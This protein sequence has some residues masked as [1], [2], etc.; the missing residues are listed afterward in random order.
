MFLTVLLEKM[1]ESP[2]DC[3]EIKLVNL[4]GNQSWI[5]L[6]RTDAEAEAPILWPPN[7][8]SQFI[9]KDPDSG[10]V[11][12]KG[13]GGRQWIRWL[14]DITDSMDISLRQ[15]QEIVKD[16][17]AWC[18]AVYVVADSQTRLDDWTRA[19]ITHTYIYTHKCVC[20]YIYT[21]TLQYTHTH[22]LE[23][24]SSYEVAT[25]L[26]VGVSLLLLEITVT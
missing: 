13:R 23:I 20:T 6:G 4:K 17:K 3:K 2:L 16:R 26:L 14:D 10:K 8:N 1:L 15:L 18:A 5:F 22:V 12:G 21:H 19:I 25:L 7:A 24:M 11:E 9:G